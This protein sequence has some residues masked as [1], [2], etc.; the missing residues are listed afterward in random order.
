M[1]KLALFATG[2]W[3]VSTSGGTQPSQ[4]WEQATGINRP[5]WVNNGHS[6]TMLFGG[7]AGLGL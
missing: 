2:K 5:L 1:K 4:D 3:Q 7:F 6:E